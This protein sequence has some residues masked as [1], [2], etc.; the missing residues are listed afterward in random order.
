MPDDRD[1]EEIVALLLEQKER[2]RGS[3]KARSAKKVE[4][5][6]EATVA[7]KDGRPDLGF[8]HRDIFLFG[9]PFRPVEERAQTRSNG[10]FVFKVRGD[11]ELGVP[12]GEDRLV[13]IWLVTAFQQ[14]GCPKD[15]RIPVRHTGDILRAFD[16]PVDGHEM[17]LL[18]QRIDRLF[19]AHFTVWERYWEVG[20]GQFRT[21][22]IRY[23]LL[24][25]Y[26]LSFSH[27][28]ARDPHL[29]SKPARNRRATL[30]K[31]Q[32]PRNQHTTG[33]DFF[34]LDDRFADYIRAHSVPLDLNM[35][36]VLKDKPPVLDLYLFESYRSYRLLKEGKS[37]LFLPVFGPNGLVCQLGTQVT[38]KWKQKQLIRR[39][40]EELSRYWLACPNELTEDGET[41]VMRPL[42]TVARGGKVRLLG[43]QRRPRVPESGAPPLDP[44]HAS[45]R[46]VRRVR[47]R[48]RLLLERRQRRRLHLPRRGGPPAPSAPPSP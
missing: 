25:A 29:P 17:E 12:Y 48:R 31:P 33:L 13:L 7:E 41:L 45:L 21:R 16:I 22:K 30:K 36:R 42:R 4:Q 38:E 44:S 6:I 11:P 32:K 24:S 5:L 23:Q 37:E 35:V 2:P 1:D 14:L 9:L 19:E 40:Q 28:E 3:S 27:Q 10:H 15:N 47:R 39:W 34:L 46:R 18:E 20:H 8:G 43:V 26:D